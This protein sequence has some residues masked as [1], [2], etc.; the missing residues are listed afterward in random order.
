ME[1]SGT[2]LGREVAF[3][4]VSASAHQGR[5]VGRNGVD[6]DFAG[7]AG[8]DLVRDRRQRLQP[9]DRA[10]RRH[11][12][13]RVVGLQIAPALERP[14]RPPGQRH[15]RRIEDEACA[16]RPVVA[17]VLDDV[18]TSIVPAITQY[19]EPPSMTSARRRGKLRVRCRSG[20]CIRIR[21]ACQPRKVSM[22]GTPT[23]SLVTCS[24]M[25]RLGCQRFL[26]A[27]VGANGGMHHGVETGNTVEFMLQC[28]ISVVWPLSPEAVTL[29]QKG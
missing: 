15:Q 12:R 11:I 1:H 27:S 4:Q 8:C 3:R 25:E 6:D 21:S 23:A 16:G 7:L 13:R 2:L 5:N 9:D 14:G 22:S 10:H 29:P 26:H 24:M 20:G 28:S 18:R 17:L 19:I